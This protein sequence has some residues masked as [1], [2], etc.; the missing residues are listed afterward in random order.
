M[1]EIFGGLG[2]SGIFI[3]KT[4]RADCSYNCPVSCGQLMLRESSMLIRLESPP[5]CS[6]QIL[7]RQSI[8]V[9]SLFW[10]PVVGF[11]SQDSVAFTVLSCSKFRV[12]SH[13][14]RGKLCEICYPKRDGRTT[15]LILFSPVISNVGLPQADG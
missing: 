14:N 12:T 6:D 4:P 13:I 5:R 15:V 7:K 8:A 3:K 11:T 1:D 2:S 9:A 10:D